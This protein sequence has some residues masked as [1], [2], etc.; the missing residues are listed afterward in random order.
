M[1]FQRKKYF[2]RLSMHNFCV[3]VYFCLFLEK[4]CSF[5]ISI[6]QTG[7]RHKAYT[8]I[9][10]Y[11]SIDKPMYM[12]CTWKHKKSIMSVLS[13]SLRYIHISFYVIIFTCYCHGSSFWSSAKN[14]VV[15]LHFCSHIILF[16]L[17]NLKIFRFHFRILQ[18]FN[19]G[20]K[21]YR[22]KHHSKK[23]LY[24]NRCIRWN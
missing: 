24:Q 8:I 20:S 21:V 2:R 4:E 23:A 3:M 17:W 6:G 14:T 15:N 10:S 11:F 1:Y 7:W 13:L 9:F 12:F 18:F 16:W 19:G 22:G 5:A